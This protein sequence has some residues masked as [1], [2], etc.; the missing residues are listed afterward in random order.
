MS[1]EHEKET[2]GGLL[3]GL[4]ISARWRRITAISTSGLILQH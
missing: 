4:D 1:I 2:D 3:I